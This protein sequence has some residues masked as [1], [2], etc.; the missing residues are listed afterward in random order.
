[1]AAEREVVVEV[2]GVE[3]AG[4]CQQEVLRL[5]AAG[6][7]NR[8]RRTM[9]AATVFAMV[10]VAGREAA[11]RCQQV[12]LRLEAAAMDSQHWK[13]VEMAGREAAAAGY[14]GYSHAR[15]ASVNQGSTLKSGAPSSKAE[16]RPGVCNMQ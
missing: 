2:S 15:H 14:Y 4:R 16:P 8:Q 9:K 3:A 10:E 1:M 11:G 5:E 12:V 13:A 7:V 6:A